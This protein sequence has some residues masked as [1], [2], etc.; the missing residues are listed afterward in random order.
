MENE[1]KKIEKLSFLF[2]TKA[3]LHTLELLANVTISDK[4]I[5]SSKAYSCIY[6]NRVLNDFI[7]ESFNQKP[8][9]GS[10]ISFHSDLENCFTSE[11]K[12]NIKG[13]ETFHKNLSSDI[14]I[15]FNE[16]QKS[17]SK[18]LM[19]DSLRFIT[20]FLENH[21]FKICD[22]TNTTH[23]LQ[24]QNI[25]FGKEK[26]IKFLRTPKIIQLDPIF[27][28][29]L[30][31]REKPQIQFS[32]SSFENNVEFFW[33][34][35]TREIFASELCALSIFEYDGLPPDFYFDLIKQMWDES[36]HSKFYLEKSISFFPDVINSSKDKNLLN[37]INN[38]NET[39]K[40]PIPKEKN[41]IDSFYDCN[42][43]ERLVFLNIRTEAPA[44]ARLKTKM[45]S[46]YCSFQTDIK[47]SFLLD[48][49][50]EISH[51]S[52]GYKWFK[53][54]YPNGDERKTRLEEIDKTRGLILYIALAENSNTD[55]FFS[56][57]EEMSD[58]DYF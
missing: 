45:E 46:E 26:P 50:D 41:F 57:K 43:D 31:V 6:I 13:I 16:L 44:V 27:E 53:F 1:L 9:K 7:F 22:I 3:R 2:L 58:N 19:Y 14:I 38:Y 8:Q 24:Y 55:Y 32:E 36:R 54:L 30:S 52:I 15:Y 18:N 11:T 48:R 40:L 51:S 5:A 35:A 34:L 33:N 23:T 29:K 12:V 28:P 37:I 4:Y 39:G 56:L 42:L 21:I 17:G 20:E 10:W 25:I 47:E 49:I